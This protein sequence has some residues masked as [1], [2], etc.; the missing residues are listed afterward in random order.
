[1]FCMCVYVCGVHANCA[2][3]HVYVCAC[4]YACVECS[5]CNCALSMYVVMLR[6]PVDVIVHTSKFES[7]LYGA[8]GM[9]HM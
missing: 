1:M 6:T 5:A 7:A 2:H 9:K 3:V 4:Q 8:H